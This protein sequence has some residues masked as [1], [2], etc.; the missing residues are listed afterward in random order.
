MYKEDNLSL[1]APSATYVST[2]AFQM[3]DCLAK[4]SK[5]V[6]PVFIICAC[7]WTI[8]VHSFLGRPTFLTYLSVALRSEPEH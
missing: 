2:I 7:L 1:C 6:A 3:T 4:S 8:I 5:G